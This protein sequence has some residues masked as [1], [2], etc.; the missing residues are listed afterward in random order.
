MALAKT[1][2]EEHYL[3]LAKYQRMLKRLDAK[4]R[5]LAIQAFAPQYAQVLPDYKYTSLPDITPKTL[6]VPT[7][8]VGMHTS[9]PANCY[10]D[11]HAEHGNQSSS[12]RHYKKGKK[13]ILCYERAGKKERNL[14][15]PFN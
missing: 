6:L 11:S 4:D 10:M 8:Y 12:S 3:F 14:S 15:A 5:Y 2:A 13:E 9:N 1:A 7:L